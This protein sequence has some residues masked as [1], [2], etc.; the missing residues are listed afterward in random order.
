MFSKIFNKITDIRSENVCGN[1]FLDNRLDS[2]IKMPGGF[3]FNDNSLLNVENPDTVLPL[4]IDMVEI[5]DITPVDK[6]TSDIT[7]VDAVE[8]EYY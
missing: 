3:I 6:Y 2:D 8:D 7:P 1:N 4:H 5:S